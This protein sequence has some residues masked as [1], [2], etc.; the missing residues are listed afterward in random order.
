MQKIKYKTGHYFIQNYL[1]HQ[2]R[3]GSALKTGRWKVSGSIPG[4]VCQ[5][6]RSEFPWFSPKFP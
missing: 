6:S 5:P 1:L 4:R 2:W 3:S